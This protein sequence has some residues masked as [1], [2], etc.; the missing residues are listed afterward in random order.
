[1]ELRDWL[2]L[3]VKGIFLPLSLYLAA[4]VIVY[5]ARECIPVISVSTSLKAITPTLIVCALSAWKT[6]DK[7]RGNSIFFFYSLSF[8]PCLSLFF[9]CSCFRTLWSPFPVSQR[10]YCNWNFFF[11]ALFIF[12]WG[13]G[14]NSWREKKN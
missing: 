9:S 5:N 3:R 12:R 7:R 1:M 6:R 13:S 4:K 10:E 11:V 2:A 8:S 14:I